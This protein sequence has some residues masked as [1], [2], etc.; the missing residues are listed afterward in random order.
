MAAAELN[1]LEEGRRI[2]REYLSKRGWAKEWRR[3]L[4][5]QLYPAVQ[6]EELEE[7]ER[8]VDQ[9]EEEAE[10]GFSA[11]YDQWRKETSPQAREVLRGIYELLGRRRDLGFIGQ[12]IV[13]RLKR[14]FTSF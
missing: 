6:R 14:E 7:K 11:A 3:A 2:A 4:N 10:A 5:T 1:P 8:R 12:R 13:D 9:M